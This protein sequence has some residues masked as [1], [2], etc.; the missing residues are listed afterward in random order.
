MVIK[1][2]LVLYHSEYK[3]KG[4]TEKEIT[5]GPVIFIG[6]PL[7]PLSSALFTFSF[8]FLLYLNLF[9]FLP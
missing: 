9:L 5:S 1:C 4:T 2:L 8:F 6:F 7:P 3:N